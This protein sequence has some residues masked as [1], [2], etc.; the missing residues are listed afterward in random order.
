MTTYRLEPLANQRLD[1]IYQYTRARWGARQAEAYISGLFDAFGEIA[2]RQTPWR[3]IPAE[4][5]VVGYFALC[6]RH[7][8]FWR[9]MDDGAVAIAAILHE[10]MDVASRLRL[11]LGY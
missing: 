11:E 1:E 5:G 3:A 7:L 8:I 9:E 4:Y 10:R 2:A 6:G